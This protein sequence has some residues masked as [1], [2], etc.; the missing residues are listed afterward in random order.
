MTNE[1]I[2]TGNKIIIEFMGGKIDPKNRRFR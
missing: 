1:E 2:L